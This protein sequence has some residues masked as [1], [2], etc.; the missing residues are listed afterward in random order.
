[1]EVD[2]DDSS[3]D[4]G[5]SGRRRTVDEKKG[6]V[7]LWDLILANFVGIPCVC[8]GSIFFGV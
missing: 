5:I 3:V 7:S 4:D 1:M 8:W 2:I 6:F